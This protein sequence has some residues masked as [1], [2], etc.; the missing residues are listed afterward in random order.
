MTIQNMITGFI[1]AVIV[2]VIS[3]EIKLLS[4]SGAAAAVILGFFI[5]GLGG[6]KWSVPLLTFFILSSLLSKFRKGKNEEVENYFEKSEVRDYLQVLSNG[7]LAGILVIV[8]SFRPNEL[9]YIM[10]LATLA[11]VCA[12]TWATEIGTIRKTATY[13]I[14]DFKPIAQGT[15]GG[16]SMPGIFGAFL[17]SSIISL[18]GLFWLNSNIVLTIFTVIIT[19]VIGCMFD[20]VLGAAVQLQY[21]CVQCGKITEKKIH[22]GI[23]SSRIRGMKGINN[24]TVNFLSALFGILFIVLIVNL[25]K[26]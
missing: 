25:V 4:K 21:R 6:L 18:S 22:C 7:G 19:G 13:N 10:Y 11:V 16:I 14:L 12:D 17:G 3:Y 20:S 8:Y 5:F 1:A 24:D 15:S 2:S 23:P 9:F 26:L